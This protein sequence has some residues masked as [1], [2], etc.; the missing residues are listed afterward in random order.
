[1]YSV[2]YD[3][4]DKEPFGIIESRAGVKTAHPIHGSANNWAIRYNGG[5]KTI[6]YGLASSEFVEMG[7]EFTNSFKSAFTD[8]GRVD[9]R[10][11]LL[12]LKTEQY[13]VAEIIYGASLARSKRRKNK[14]LR[15]VFPVV[16]HL[17]KEFFRTELINDAIRTGRQWI[18]KNK[19]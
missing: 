18:K 14:V 11:K 8:T 17:Q 4:I 19:G 3:P 9:R 7:H 12:S 1:M 16:G 15:K 5:D 2:I 6:P 13:V 10:A